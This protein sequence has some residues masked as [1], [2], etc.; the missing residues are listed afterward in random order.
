[1]V[2]KKFPVLPRGD[3]KIPLPLYA[4]NP[5]SLM[6]SGIPWDGVEGVVPGQGTMHMLK[7]ATPEMG[8]RALVKN[9]HKHFKEN[10]DQLLGDY[11]TQ[12]YA[13]LAT[14]TYGALLPKFGFDTAAPLKSVDLNKLLYAIP[15][16]EGYGELSPEHVQL[17][18][19]QLMAEG[20]APV[21][22]ELG[23]TLLPAPAPMKP[24]VK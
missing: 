24:G 21:A 13:P 9:L 10:P 16:I 22:N 15:K 3:A 11:F 19:A 7:F 8:V 5:G 23:G 20:Y 2:K 18:K 12:S 6:D 14:D 1:M 4:N 17:A